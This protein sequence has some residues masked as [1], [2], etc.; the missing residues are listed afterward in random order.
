MYVQGTAGYYQQLGLLGPD[1]DVTDRETN[2]NVLFN[3]ALSKVAF[4]PFGYL[5]D[6]YRCERGTSSCVLNKP[7][8]ICS[9]FRWDM[10]DGVADE[11]NLNCHWV[12]LRL[13]IQGTTATTSRPCHV[14]VCSAVLQ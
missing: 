11:K 14:V 12:K 7:F 5:V 6:K 2:I 4:M 8:T 3:M 9:V 1:V 10:Y 13:D